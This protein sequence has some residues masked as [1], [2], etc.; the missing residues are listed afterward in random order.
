[1]GTILEKRLSWA[2]VLT[3][4]LAQ[5][6]I[7]A[8]E[9]STAS[10]RN[11]D[12]VSHF[13]LIHGMVDAA[14]HGDNP[15]DFW[16]AETSTGVPLARLYQ[17]LA[18]FLVAGLYFAFGKT[19]SLWTL[20]HWIKY[21][22]MVLLPVPFYL[23]ALWL[24][25]PPLTAAAAALLTPMI[26][27]PG[28]GQLGMDL[29][30]W[31]GFGLFPQAVGAGLMLLSLGLSFKS[32]REGKRVTL[33]GAL[34]G[35]TLLAH[36]I[37]GWMAALSACL[38]AVM[39][40]RAV[41]RLVRIRRLVAMGVAAAL[42]A[43]FQLVPLVTDGYLI[44]RSRTEPAEK[45][46][47]FG[48][49]KVLEWLFTGQMM[50]HDRVPVL[51]LLVFFGAGLL[52]WRWRKTR[53]IESAHAFLLIGAA[54][55]LLVFFGRPTWGAL[56]NLI[57]ATRDLHLHRVLGGVQVF[58]LFLAAIGLAELWREVAKRWHFAAAIALTGVLLTPLVIERLKWVDSHMELEQGT[59]AAVQRDG[60]TLDRAI[61]LARQRGGRVFAGLR[62][63]WGPRFALGRT[64]VYAFLTTG[65]TPTITDAYNQ[66]ALP[67]DLIG[68]FNQSKASEYR[69]FNIRTV[70]T[71]PVSGAPEF[72]KPLG[73][74]GHFR[75]FEAPGEG[76]FGVVDVVAAADTTRDNFF[77]L[78]NPWLHS[79]WP[80]KNQYIWLDFHG[81]APK[82]LPRL[83]PGFLPE[84]P[85]PPGDSGKA[86]NERQTGQVYEAD[87]DVLRPAW[88]L[89]RMTFHPAWKMLV[90]GQP[91]KTA[92]L[93]PGFL[94]A[95]VTAGRH[96]VFC[97]YEPG[98]AKWVL[99]FAGW[100]L[101]LVMFGVEHRGRL[102]RRS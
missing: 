39:P 27:G 51:T 99:L 73:D 92:M 81:N 35:L 55:W 8:P 102:R 30:S 6:I 93:S 72:L 75:A 16:S 88:V 9:L 63:T 95:Q 20:F 89:L 65:L 57:G 101:T 33:A 71:I 74:V 7:L 26:A 28:T 87:I 32:I 80:E 18:H 70:L 45:Y 69:V 31:I 36:L 54:F 21:L 56:L 48:A 4:V 86:M 100:G 62:D 83:T 15:L 25:L 77:D 14:E 96:H 94:G 41:P 3:V 13:A 50:D 90:D 23:A 79:A 24:D 97:R 84:L 68:R 40:D 37:Y 29:R 42:I 52:L 82:G 76:Y 2:I 67:S 98:N 19:V 1:M 60:P 44:N 22:S 46:D 91:L 12:N 47:S 11:S 49:T 59:F 66:T 85:S 58:L 5:A 17:P 43:A 61:A 38:L 34:I 10:Y 64:P 53:K 78:C